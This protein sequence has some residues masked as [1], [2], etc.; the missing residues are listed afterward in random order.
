MEKYLSDVLDTS[1]FEKGFLN[2]I[3]APCGC[4]KT[5]AAIH[6]IAPLASKPRKAIYLIDTRLGKERL[7]NEDRLAFPFFAYPVCISD[8]HNGFYEDDD[9]V[10]VT[11][12]AQFGYWCAQY[13][14]YAENYEYI[15]CDEPQ[16]LVNFSEI[17]KNGEYKVNAHKIA[18]RAICD[19]VKRGNVMVVAITATP[20]PL[21]K[22][23]CRLKDIPIDR[24]NLHHY[25][26]KNRIAYASLPSIIENLPL[27]QRGGIYIKHVKPMLKI[28]QDLRKRG[29]NPLLLWSLDYEEKP[30]SAEQLAARQYIIDHEGVPPEY[31]IFVFNATAE[32]SI[33]IRSHMDFFIANNTDET[34]ITQSRGRYRGD[35]ETLYV[36]D[37]KGAVILPAEYLGR[38]LFME[39]L[40]ELRTRLNLRKDAKGHVPSIDD[41]LTQFSNCGYNCDEYTKN[42]KKCVTITKA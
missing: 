31:D 21:E 33:N 3:Y 35:L 12:Y 30:L 8:P 7:A 37:M 23:D 42:R 1:Y 36:Y 26:E 17:G 18:R 22:L 10:C 19:T 27:G 16:N 14:N 20:K 28:E 40:K 2:V 13:P 5:T 38:P 29:F 24:E 4:G 6:K 39:D 11:T 32:T 9:K 15:I 25:I 41:M 34:S